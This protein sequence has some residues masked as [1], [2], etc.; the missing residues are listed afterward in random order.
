MKWI[1]LLLLIAAGAFIYFN[2]DLNKVNS[3]VNEEATNALKQEKTIKVFFDADQQNKDE[4]Q[5]TINEHF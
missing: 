4:M 2:V 3:T 1:I 5:Q